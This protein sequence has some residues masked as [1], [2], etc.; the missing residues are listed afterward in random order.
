MTKAEKVKYAIESAARDE[1][2]ESWK[3]DN[4]GSTEGFDEAY[5]SI[6][7]EFEYDQD[8]IY[9]WLKEKDNEICK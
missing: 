1:A 3:E 2:R 5:G 4:F 8:D 9:N 7:V 6:G